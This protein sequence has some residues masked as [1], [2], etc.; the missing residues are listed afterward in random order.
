MNSD[1]L[2]DRTKRF[3]YRVIRL[4]RTLP[5]AGE[6]DIIGKQLLRSA[7]SVAANYCAATRGRSRSEFISK[8]GIVVEESDET[9]FWLEC[10]SD[11][12]IVKGELLVPLIKEADELVAI[13]ASA[14][15]TA[16]ASAA[17]RQN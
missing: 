8:L 10:L 7:T 5:S 14:R 11:N 1:E 3:A 12:A 2:R 9:L 16:R 15:K 17:K 6:G 4:Y 13:F